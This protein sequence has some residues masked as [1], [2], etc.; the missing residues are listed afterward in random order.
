MKAN[1]STKQRADFV[2]MEIP[3]WIKV[4]ELVGFVEDPVNFVA[5]LTLDEVVEV[6]V[7][8]GWELAA[9]GFSAY[10]DEKKPDRVLQKPLPGVG[11]L[12]RLHIRLWSDGVVV[13]NAHL[14]VPTVD[15]VMRLSPHE[16][17]HDLG[18]AYVAYLFIKH[19]YQVELIY[20]GNMTKN[21]DGFAIKIF[22]ANAGKRP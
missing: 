7:K 22:K 2:F 17:I 6:L 8:E 3:K 11:A 14:D 18:K 20:L 16:S 9:H 12:M 4:K 21:N 5:M 10:L 15:S 1:S 13:G 19:G